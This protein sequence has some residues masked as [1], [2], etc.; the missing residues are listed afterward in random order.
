MELLGDEVEHI[1]EIDTL[2]GRL[3]HLGH[4]MICLT[5]QQPRK[6]L[7][8][9]E[10][11]RAD[12]SDNVEYLKKEGKLLELLAPRAAPADL[13]MMRRSAAT[14]SKTIPA[15]ST[16]GS[17]TPSPCWTISRRILLF[18]KRGPHD[19]PRSGQPQQGPGPQSSPWW[20][21]ASG[22]PPPSTTAYLPGIRSQ[23]RPRDLR[24]RHPSGPWRPPRQ[25]VVEQLIRPTG[26]IDPAVVVR[27]ATGQVDDLLGRSAKCGPG[28]A[29][30]GPPS[31]SMA[32]A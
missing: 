17:G 21:T 30:A 32:E 12:L 16:S 5:T 24:V 26:L 13:E 4:V 18:I 10:Q 29:G 22:C 7:R 27:P 19:H 20:S 28:A 14:A 9:I 1:S 31:P 6:L 11:I 8:A 23:G 25:Q 2:T 15:T 3:R